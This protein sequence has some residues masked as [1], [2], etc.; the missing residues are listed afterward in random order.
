MRAGDVCRDDSSARVPG[1]ASSALA[2]NVDSGD[3]QAVNGAPLP[4]R[5]LSAWAANL[6]LAAVF[7]ALALLAAEGVVRLL[8][9]IGPAILVTDPRVGKRFVPGF[10]GRVF[11]DEAEREVEVRIN[12]AGFP[13]PEWSRRKPE[14]G[15]RIAVVGDSMTAAIATD[16]ER[17]FVGR[18]EAALAAEVAPRPVEVLNFGVSS[19]STASALVTWR[20]VV[21]GYVPDLVLLA[22]FTGNDVGDNSPRLTRAP[23]VY[24]DLDADGRLVPGERPPPTPVLVRWLDRH[25]R[26]YVWQKV[27]LRRLRG[28]GRASRGLEPAQRIFARVGGPDVEDAWRLTAALLGQLRDEVE[29]AGARLAV[30]VIPCAEQV[31]DE[32][33]SDLARRARDA[34]LE[35]EREGPSRR[36]AQIAARRGIPLADLAPALAATARHSPGEPASAGRLFLLG[37]FHLSDEGHRVVAEALRRFLTE[38]EGRGLLQPR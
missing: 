31:D 4:G 11:V 33:W 34:G 19:A 32:L 21:A 13:G 7:L 10:R 18:L 35:L 9:P 17:R 36:L 16:E 22:F 37:R 28:A 5:G 29:A 20:E 24:Y 1:R 38:G 12:S 23:R 2:A 15:L 14:G 3:D 8:S 26:L 27:A 25:S 6:A 30:T